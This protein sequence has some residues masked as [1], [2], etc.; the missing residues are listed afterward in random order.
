[1]MI[2]TSLRS[3]PRLITISPMPRPRIPRMEMLRS[4]LSRLDTV[5][6]PLSVSPKTTTSA[7]VINSTISSWVGLVSAKRKRGVFAGA[8]GVSTAT[9][10]LLRAT[11][12]IRGGQGRAHHILPNY[13]LL[14]REF[15][16]VC[17]TR[18]I[19]NEDCGGGDAELLSTIIARSHAANLWPP[20]FQ[21]TFQICRGRQ[22][23]R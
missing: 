12:R 8:S 15:P 16:W 19:A 11:P 17:I 2:A 4:R 20:M 5:A 9:T 7:I 1:A 18:Q 21:T 23:Q 22:A 10:H 14:A 6:K 3:M 13:L